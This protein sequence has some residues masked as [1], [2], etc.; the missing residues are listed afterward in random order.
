METRRVRWALVALIVTS[1]VL[2]QSTP[3]RPTRPRRTIAVD[4]GPPTPRTPCPEGMVRVPAGEFVMG[5]R[6]GEG[7]DWDGHPAHRVRLG[8][9][10]IDR[11][12]VTVAQYR[13]CVSA[14]R[15]RLNATINPGSVS[16][17]STRFLNGLCNANATDR[18]N[19]P[20]NCLDWNEADVYCRWAQKR[21]PTD[22]EWEYA[23]RGTDERHWPWGNDLPDARRTNA[24]GA[25]SQRF[26]RERN[27]GWTLMYPG[28]DGWPV[29]APVGSYPQGR[30]PFGVD[31]MAG[32]VWEWTSDWYEVRYTTQGDVTVNP[33]GPAQGT[34][35]VSRGGAWDSHVIDRVCVTGRSHLVPDVRIV[36]QGVRC[37]SAVRE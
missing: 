29:T 8:A 37:A 17:E 5:S 23:A 19:H 9:Y 15:C 10:C 22:A 36:N 16:A 4:A 14:G 30:S 24:A 11:V 1:A 35:R 28:D 3:R 26:M 32:N 13:A 6:D 25:E 2:A 33:T 31:D 20:I 18:E 27:V 34:H 12:E 7:G 21:L